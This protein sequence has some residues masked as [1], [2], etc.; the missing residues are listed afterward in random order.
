VQIFQDEDVFEAGV[1]IKIGRNMGTVHVCQ[2][3]RELTGDLRGGY[4]GEWMSG[5]CY[6]PKPDE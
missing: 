1:D 3:V 4:M 6:Y 2:Y 5:C